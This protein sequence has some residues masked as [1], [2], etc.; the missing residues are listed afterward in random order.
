MNFTPLPI[1]E[2]ELEAQ[3]SYLVSIGMEPVKVD[4][5]INTM[6]QA[7]I[8]CNEHVARMQQEMYDVRCEIRKRQL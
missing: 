3:R 5:L 4:A 1:D 8:D 6:R 7:V 2:K